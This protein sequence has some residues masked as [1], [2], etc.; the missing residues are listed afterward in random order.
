MLAG[1]V[2]VGVDGLALGLMATG[3][4][5]HAAGAHADSRV[6]D[7]RRADPGRDID[8]WLADRLVQRGQAAN[9]LVI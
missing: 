8:A 9:R 3:L 1:G 2:L 6:R 7:A 5:Q 4:D